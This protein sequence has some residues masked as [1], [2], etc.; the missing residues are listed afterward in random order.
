M[1]VANITPCPGQLA[2]GPD[3]PAGP[4]PLF[5]L[6]RPAKEELADAAGAGWTCLLKVEIRCRSVQRGTK[7]ALFHDAF[8][9]H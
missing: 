9:L 7:H 5:V 3:E 2:L 4:L 1:R 6:A 8:V